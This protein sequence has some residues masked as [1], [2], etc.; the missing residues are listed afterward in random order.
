MVRPK[1]IVGIDISHH[2]HFEP[3]IQSGRRIL[4]GPWTTLMYKD[5]RG[6]YLK[7]KKTLLNFT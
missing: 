6:I 7:K 5:M 2:I 3:R 4:S 1:T